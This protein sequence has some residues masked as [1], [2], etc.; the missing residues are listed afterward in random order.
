MKLQLITEGTRAAEHSVIQSLDMVIRRLGRKDSDA[1]A[2]AAFGFKLPA[3]AI[4]S[5]QACY[6][7]PD[8][9]EIPFEW[10]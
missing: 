2:C 9:L 4:S 7:P 10:V 8:R 3:K 6:N 5:K 1:D